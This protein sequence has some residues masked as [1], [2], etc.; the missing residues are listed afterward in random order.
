MVVSTV[1]VNIAISWVVITP[2]F[3]RSQKL[4]YPRER[5][6]KAIVIAM[7]KM[8][9]ILFSQ[10]FLRK[11][12]V[13]SLD[14]SRCN[15]PHPVICLELPGRGQTVSLSPKHLIFR[16]VFEAARRLSS[17]CARYDFRTGPT[18]ARVLYP[19]N[20]DTRRWMTL[21]LVTEFHEAEDVEH[22]AESDDSHEYRH[23]KLL[24]H[25]TVVFECWY[26]ILRLK[27]R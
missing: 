13:V 25:G 18:Q 20:C 10:Y 27:R 23:C 8:S 9:C 19:W 26:R 17:E 6:K 16:L 1:T 15:Q 2:H 22:Q 21:G 11:S 5:A 24:C 4:T 7:T 3:N 14:P 12:A